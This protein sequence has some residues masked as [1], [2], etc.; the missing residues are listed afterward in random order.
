MSQRF[1]IAIIYLLLTSTWSSAGEQHNVPGEVVSHEFQ[2]DKLSE[3]VKLFVEIGTQRLPF[4]VDTG[5][6]IACFDESL[7]PLLGMPVQKVNAEVSGK[8]KNVELFR[9][10]EATIGPIALTRDANVTVHNF[11]R[12]N[13]VARDEIRGLIGMSDLKTIRVQF[14]RDAG[15]LKILSQL[16]SDLG[17]PVKISY[18][19]TG[20]PLVECTVAKIPGAEFDIDTGM[21]DSIHFETKMFDTL[22]YHRKIQSMGR[23]AGLNGFGELR[24]VTVGRLTNFSIGDLEFRNI[25]VTRSGDNTIG[26]RFLSRFITTFDFPNGVMY[27][28]KGARFDEPD[29]EGIQG[30]GVFFI[31]DD[32]KVVCVNDDGPA[33]KAGLKVQDVIEQIDSQDL[34]GKTLF[35]INRSFEKPGQD[36]KLRIRRGDETRLITIAVPKPPATFDAE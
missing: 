7:K 12:T 10:P 2:I 8:G 19:R 33:D 5:A 26:L 3:H 36:L 13:R 22:L 34:T 16:G 31:G 30:F 29:V 35:Q 4:V 1:H 14:D 20:V 21:G 32:L 15:K 18:P 6:S 25:L 27:L 17:T 23:I 28:K 24:F 9:A 11:R